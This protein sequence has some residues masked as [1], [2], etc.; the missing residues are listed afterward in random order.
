VLFGIRWT[1]EEFQERQGGEM[2]REELDQILA[3]H[4]LWVEGNS[5]GERADLHGS[6]LHLANLSGF[7][8]RHV[9]FRGSNLSH[10][11]FRDA[12]LIR[13]DLRWASLIHADF[14]WADLR[15]ARLPKTDTFLYT[16]WGMAH[17]QREMI[18]IGCQY[19]S[20]SDWAML[21]DDE[22]NKMHIDALDWWTTWKYVVLAIAAA[23]EPYKEEEK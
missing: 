16:P 23:C 19:R 21:S 11:N 4:R 14:R 9:D 15:G 6:D 7:D 5:G 17:I 8:L 13:A 20:T 3:K 1:G 10:T 12:N 18:R 22:I 2:N